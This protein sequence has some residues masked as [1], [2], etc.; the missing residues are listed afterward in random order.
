MIP[1][2]LEIIPHLKW[3][4]LEENLTVGIPLSTSKP[5]MNLFTD[6]SSEG[7]G[8]HLNSMEVSGKWDTSTAKLHINLLEMR[9]VRLAI[10]LRNPS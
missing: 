2:E 1:T 5:D 9:G 7:W 6:A 8:A 4:L 3:W 10:Q